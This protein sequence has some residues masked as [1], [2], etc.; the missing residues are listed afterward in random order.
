MKLILSKS[1]T[2]KGN[3][4]AIK[5]KKREIKHQ[6]LNITKRSSQYFDTFIVSLSV[7]SK[8]LAVIH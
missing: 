7:T 3:L 8:A 5:G 4:T 1:F 6:I 2:Q